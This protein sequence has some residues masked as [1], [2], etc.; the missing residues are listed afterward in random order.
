MHA[1]RLCMLRLNIA[2]IARHARLRVLLCMHAL[3][4][5][6]AYLLPCKARGL[7]ACVRVRAWAWACACVAAV[8]FAC[9]RAPKVPPSSVPRVCAQ[10]IFFC[11]QLL[12]EWQET[13]PLLD[14]AP[15]MLQ[16]RVTGS[17]QAEAVSCLPGGTAMAAGVF[18]PVL[19][20]LDR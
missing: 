9:A 4:I 19:R 3:T 10:T 1:N 14:F 18:T 20:A 7:C 8:A 12:S 6:A 17:E 15:D 5:S 11:A 16:S 2:S 13:D